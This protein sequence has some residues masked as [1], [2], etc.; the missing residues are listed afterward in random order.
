MEASPNT[1]TTL[2]RSRESLERY[3]AQPKGHHTQV[4]EEEL[5]G[6]PQVE[7][8]NRRFHEWISITCRKLELNYPR[9]T[10]HTKRF[11]LL[12]RGPRPVVD[13][14]EP[15]PWISALT[16]RGRPYGLL[17]ENRFARLVRPLNGRL[18]ILL[19]MGA[20]YI[21]GLS[22]LVHA[23]SYSSPAKSWISCTSAY[24]SAND[25]C[26]L[27]GSACA[28][29]T[30]TSF[31]FRCPAQC[32]SVKIQNPRTI[33]NEQAN[34]VPLV[35][36]GG[37]AN[38]TYRGD[39]FLCAAG[40]QAGFISNSRGGCA[41]VN[42]IGNFTNF[43]PRSSHGLTSLGFPTVFP[44]S[45]RFSATSSLSHCADL[46][47]EALVVNVLVTVALFLVIRP[48]PI[49]LFWCM[50]SI[51]FWHITLFSQPRSF[52][53]DI[54]DGFGT[55]LPVLFVSYAFWRSAFRFVL[56]AFAKMPIEATILY[57]GPYW[58]T[59]LANLTTERIP[60]DRLTAADIV[61]Q[62]GGLA[63]LIIIVLVLLVI[64]INQ[65]RVIR[66]TGWLPYYLGWY[67]LGGLATLVLALL[68]TLNLRLHHYIIAI[69]LMPGTAFPTRL[70][71]IYQGFLL[72][73]FLNGTGAFG[74]DS[75][76]QTAAQLRRDG[77][78]GTDLPS[79]VTN[80]TNYNSSVPPPEQIIFWSPLPSGKDW[81]GFALL[82]DDVERY[83]G[84]AF[85]YS[86]S[87]LHG[88][89]PHFFRLAFIK[90]GV[91]GDFTKA[92]TLWPNGTWIDPVPGPS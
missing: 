48:R 11:L 29:F 87:A 36:G 81:D 18:W 44:L 42:L 62:P 80:S 21:V 82:V 34:F 70:S 4:S 52:P 38:F 86:L 17:L 74:F 39:S 79:F 61:A 1:T 85:N 30:N 66:K 58:T 14:P 13:L 88:G 71:A 2:H 75:M 45:F 59:V 51:G 91:A 84:T 65:I 76:F 78:V 68:P 77:I 49:I 19:L 33:G 23:Q 25:G 7:G 26:G 60:I 43:L 90:E 54:A 12:M 40:I 28:P 55:F 47:S 10:L 27:D 72:G 15:S 46:R 57:L 73:L 8:Q 41:T 89:L 24:W 53:P 6:L 63:A 20:I 50:I 22:L 3:L 69:I 32:S 16:F 56:P 37:D 9:V 35:I 31:D 64:V 5:E 83:V 92:A 67:A